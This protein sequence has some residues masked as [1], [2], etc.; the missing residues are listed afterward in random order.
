MMPLALIERASSSRASSRNRVRGWYGLGSIRSMSI[1]WG[2][3]VTG[4]RAG[5]TAAPCVVVATAPGCSWT[6]ATG[7][8]GS[9]M[10]APSPRPNAFLGIADDLLGKLCIALSALAMDIVENNRFTKTRCFG[11]PNIAWDH[12]LED[13][14][15]EEAA[16]IGRHLPR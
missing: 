14:C 9:R 15:S 3:L 7:A 4:S 11:E 12:T 5:A 6:G 13:L 8:S 16:E 1:C 2:P 10:S